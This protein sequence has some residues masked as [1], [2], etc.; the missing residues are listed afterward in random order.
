VLLSVAQLLFSKTVAV[1]QAAVR[2]ELTELE[3]QELQAGINVSLHT[4]VS[5]SG[6]ITLGID[7]EDQQCVWLSASLLRCSHENTEHV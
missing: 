6:L 1:T 3:A 7:L 4:D 2:L 5:P